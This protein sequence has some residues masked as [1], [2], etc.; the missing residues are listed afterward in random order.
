MISDVQAYVGGNKLRDYN[1]VLRGA[2]AAFEDM[3]PLR[4]I[5]GIGGIVHTVHRHTGHGQHI[6]V[7]DLRKGKYQFFRLSFVQRTKGLNS[8]SP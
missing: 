4:L 3:K 7:G 2:S 6:T 5:N 8:P 1:L